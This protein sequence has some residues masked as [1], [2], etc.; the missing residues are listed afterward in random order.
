M[1]SLIESRNMIL[2]NECWVL[3]YLCIFIEM[4]NYIKRAIEVLFE[5][6]PRKATRSV[7][8]DYWM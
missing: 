4:E 5:K 7:Q 3:G 6:V 1:V 8:N 2:E